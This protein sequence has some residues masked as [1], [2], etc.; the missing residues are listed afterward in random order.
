[1]VGSEKL[2]RE[3]R[4]M[5][6]SEREQL[7]KR[8]E[9]SIKD[10][11]VVQNNQQK[12]IP[13]ASGQMVT[14][15]FWDRILIFIFSLLGVMSYGEYIKRKRLRMIKDRVAEISPPIM[16][17][18]RGV[19]YPQFGKYLYELYLALESVSEVLNMTVFNPNVWDATSPSDFKPCVEYLFEFLTN[20]RSLF[21]VSDVKSVISEYKS[22]KKVFERIEVEVENNIS[23]LDSTILTRANKIYSRLFVFKDLLEQ[24][25][26]KKLL[27]YFIDEKGKI[28]LSAVPD[29]WLTEEMEKLCNIISEIDITPMMIDVIMALKKYLESIIDKESYEYKKFSQISQNL[30]PETLNKAYEITEKLNIVDIVCILKDDPDYIPVFLV[31]EYSLVNVYKDVV[32]RKNKN[33][34]S[35]MVKDTIEEKS[36]TFY[37]LIGRTEKEVKEV[38]ETIYTE[39]NSDK[40]SLYKLNHF[41]YPT[42]FQIIY[43]FLNYF[44]KPTF[45]EAV[46]DIAV[47]GI[48]KEKYLKSTFSSII[49]SIDEIEKDV[50]VFLKHTTRGGEYYSVIG[51]FFED[52]SVAKVESSRKVLQQKITLANNL[53]GSIVVKSYDSL[54]QLN[55]YLKF[56]LQDY[57]SLSPEHILNIKTVKGIHNKILIESIK[58]GQEV[59]S[60]LLEILSY[61]TS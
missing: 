35:K 52:P 23:S 15:S 26:F 21:G 47:N 9:E 48:F 39:E 45:R 3:I 37:H 25:N 57:S 10:L 7:R 60:V 30:T 61:Y 14:L 44:W 43:S 17:V 18:R 55:K 58:R 29:F 27:R 53:A 36:N 49:L 24:V 16:N 56:I 28:S 19:L 1:M 5:P 6:P 33:L 42:A 59:L 41:A 2:E 8:M 34:A 4:K 40:L 51:R 46:N 22:L 50:S 11:K 20:T 12:S 32:V 13:S 31:P 38:L 54:S